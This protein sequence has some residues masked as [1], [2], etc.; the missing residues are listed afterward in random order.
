MLK[1]HFRENIPHASENTI[2]ELVNSHTSGEH[3]VQIHGLATNGQQQQLGTDNNNNLKVNVVSPVLVYPHSSADA[4]GSP[5]TS[6]NVKVANTNNLNFKLEDLTSALT[7]G[8]SNNNKHIAV[9]QVSQYE[10]QTLAGANGLTV[11]GA[12]NG[13]S[14]DMDGFKH[15]VIKVRSTATAGAGLSINN[16]RVAYSLEGGDFTLG[17][18]IPQNEHPTLSGNYQ[19]IIRLENV[20]FRYV[21]LICVATAQS[22]TAYV[23]NFSRSN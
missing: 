5:T 16:L 23:I 2:A 12:N 10:N 14:I 8:H 1:N 21:Q 17:E 7:A 22:P 6:F 11:L 3:K 20:G 15:L 19:G 4:E 18:V 9:R 13:T